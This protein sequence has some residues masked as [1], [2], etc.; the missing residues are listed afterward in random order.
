MNAIR[1]TFAS[2]RAWAVAAGVFA[3]YAITYLL[4]A[5]ALV[6]DGPGAFSGF[7]PLP[8][9][10]IA[11]DVGARAASWIDPAF[12]LYVSDRIVLAP[13]VPTM[14]VAILIGLLVGVNVA[15]GIEA[16]VRPPVACAG[17]PPLWAVAAL[18]SL[19]VSFSCCAPTLLV[20]LGGT[21][22]GA[23]IPAIP[24]L[25]PLSAILL[26]ATTVWAGHRLGPTASA[27]QGRTAPP[28]LLV[29]T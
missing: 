21:A 1:W 13:S 18:P 16:A 5:K 3:G 19:L 12:V 27:G 11:H 6:L 25:A 20:L 29:K 14:L 26:V 4:V 23:L 17:A 8:A 22:A 28:P 15:M 24:F 7:G 10:S 2:A 9:L